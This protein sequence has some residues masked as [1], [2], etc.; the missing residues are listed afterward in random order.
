MI[1]CQQYDH[2][3]LVCVYHYPIKLSLT[4]GRVIY[5][6]AKDT[7]KSDAGDECIS[8]KIKDGIIHVILDEIVQL[9][10]TIKNPHLEMITFD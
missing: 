4:S 2:I 7:V 8:V 1:S 9:R 5:G 6:I 10:V 3:E